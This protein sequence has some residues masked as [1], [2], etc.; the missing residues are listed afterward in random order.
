MTTTKPVSAP[1]AARPAI[2]APSRNTLYIDRMMD[3]LALLC[4]GKTPAREMVEA[5]EEHASEELQD[6]AVCN[7]VAPWATGIGTIEAAQALADT[8]EDGMGHQLSEDAYPHQAGAA[9][10]RDTSA[11]DLSERIT[12]AY[13]RDWTLKVSAD[14]NG[15]LMADETIYFGF[16]GH[17]DDILHNHLSENSAP[18]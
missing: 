17:L 1:R 14:G 3:A 9:E 18:E 13:G 5:W 12:A 6:W 2:P 15:S 8:P 10:H 7:V 16:I 4:G 11:V